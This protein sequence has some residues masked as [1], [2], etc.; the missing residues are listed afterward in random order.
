MGRLGVV[1]F[2]GRLGEIQNTELLA[3][4]LPF[5]VGG[6]LR[7]VLLFQQVVVKL[8][9]CLVIAGQLF[10][11]LFDDR[12]QIKACLIQFEFAACSCF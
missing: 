2:S 9:S 4:L 8:E 1:G 10:V 5:Q 11:L 7:L 12:A 6:H 3:L